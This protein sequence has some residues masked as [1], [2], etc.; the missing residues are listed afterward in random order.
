MVSLSPELPG[1]AD[2][3]RRFSE[4]GIVTAAAHTEANASQ[5]RR[6]FEAGLRHTTHILNAMETRSGVTRGVRDIGCAEFT[7]A[8]QEMTADVMVDS[9]GVHVADEWLGILLKCLTTERLAL[10]SDA[11]PLTGL[12]AGTYPTPDGREL[13]VSPGRDVAMIGGTDLAGSVMMM[14][15]ATKNLMRRLGMRLEDVIECATLVPA[16]VLGIE[17]RKGSVAPGK[18]ADLVALDARMRVVM[19]MVEGEIRYRAE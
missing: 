17:D 10:L 5:M 8:S 4:K 19:T 16:K 9:A 3:V 6:V 2:A 12:P 11:M 7:L 14:M 15:D 13:R 1:A 18:D